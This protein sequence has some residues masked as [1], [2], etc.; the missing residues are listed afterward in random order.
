[1]HQIIVFSRLDANGSCEASHHR[2][3]FLDRQL[4]A[5]RQPAGTASGRC[6]LLASSA[7]VKKK[8][9][10][11]DYKCRGCAEQF[12][13]LVLKSTVAACPTCGSLDLEQLPCT[14]IA[15][16]SASIRRSNLEAAQ[17][18]VR[19]GSNY[20]DKKMAELDD[21]KEHAP[22]MLRKKKKP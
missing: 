19:N 10:L 9:P 5:A 11:Y 8:M 22:Y 2:F 18:A 1:V 16:S 7:T 14:G 6:Y 20:R 17:R 15:M 12:E 3:A 13:L 4:V 21:I